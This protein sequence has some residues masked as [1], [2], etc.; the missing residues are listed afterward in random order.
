MVV[1]KVREEFWKEKQERGKFLNF[2]CKF[3][4]N[5]R[6]IFE[7]FMYKVYLENLVKD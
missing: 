5:F 4:L 3:F 1:E 6:L 7:L 2:L